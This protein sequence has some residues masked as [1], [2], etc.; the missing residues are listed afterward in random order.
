[1]I[2]IWLFSYPRT[3]T[4]PYVSHLKVKVNLH[5]DVCDSPGGSCRDEEAEGTSLRSENSETLSSNQ[6]SSLFQTLGGFALI[7]NRS[8]SR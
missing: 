6:V 3:V 5:Q 8:I 7:Q 1:M 4:P 2:V